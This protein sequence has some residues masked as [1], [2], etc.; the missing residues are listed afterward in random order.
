MP[1]GLKLKVMDS[2]PDGTSLKSFLPQSKLRRLKEAECMS[3]VGFKYVLASSLQTGRMYW[4]YFVNSQM[5]SGAYKSLAEILKVMTIRN[6]KRFLLR[7]FSSTPKGSL[8]SGTSMQGSD[9]PHAHT[10][11]WQS[12]KP[13]LHKLG[14]WELCHRCYQS[15]ATYHGPPGDWWPHCLPACIGC[16]SCCWSRQWHCSWMRASRD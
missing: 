12:C 10:H 15:L 3:L 5:G 16:R 14:P 2:L 13:H 1:H 4:A 9:H 11:Q 7:I 6:A 8:A